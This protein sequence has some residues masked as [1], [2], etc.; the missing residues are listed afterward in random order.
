MNGGLPTFGIIAYL[1]IVIGL[2]AVSVI[3]G[4]GIVVDKVPMQWDLNGNPIWFADRRIGVWFPVP[5]FLLIGASLLFR[6]RSAS[7]PAWS[8]CGVLI[9]SGVFLIG[10][11]YWHLSKIVSWSE[12]QL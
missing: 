6:A 2:A 8:D 3:Y 4:N 10:V 7:T 1:A 5:L 12:K 9:A 11:H